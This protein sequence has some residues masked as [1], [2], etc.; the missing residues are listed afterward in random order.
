MSLLLS[1]IKNIFIKGDLNGNNGSWTNTD[2]TFKNN[3]KNVHSKSNTNKVN[4]KNRTNVNKNKAK[5]NVNDKN[6]KN[7][8]L[9]GKKWNKK[10]N[11]VQKL[12]KEIERINKI[13]KDYLRIMGKD[14][15]TPEY[16]DGFNLYYQRQTKKFKISD[17]IEKLSG[18]VLEELGLGEELYEKQ[19]KSLSDSIDVVNEGYANLTNN[20]S[21]KGDIGILPCKN[22]Y[23]A[24]WACDGPHFH[25]RLQ[26]LNGAARRKREE[27]GKNVKPKTSSPYCIQSD[28]LMLCTLP[29][30]LCKSDN[31]LHWHSTVETETVDKPQ[32]INLKEEKDSY[33]KYDAIK[34]EAVEKFLDEG[35]CD[36]EMNSN[37]F[38][39][40][41]NIVTRI[42][43]PEFVDDSLIKKVV[44][45]QMNKDKRLKEI[46]KRIRIDTPKIVKDS[47]L[48]GKKIY[49]EEIA[50]MSKNVR[51]IPD[52]TANVSEDKKEN[53]EEKLST[54][55]SNESFSDDDSDG[56]STEDEVDEFSSS[57]DDYSSEDEDEPASVDAEEVYNQNLFDYQAIIDVYKKGLNSEDNMEI[58]ASDAAL[59]FILKK[60]GHHE[61]LDEDYSIDEIINRFMDVCNN[62]PEMSDDDSSSSGSSH[63]S[64]TD[65]SYEPST[66]YSTESD[67]ESSDSNESSD[68]EDIDFLEIEKEIRDREE[69]LLINNN[70]NIKMSIKKFYL[71][72]NK[73]V[74]EINRLSSLDGKGIAI[75]P[76][77]RVAINNVR[78]AIPG[79]VA[80]PPVVPAPKVGAR[81]AGKNVRWGYMTIHPMNKRTFRQGVKLNNKLIIPM[82]KYNY[83]FGSTKCKDDEP[84]ICKI[85]MNSN[86]VK[87]NR[88]WI[89]AFKGIK[90]WL[91]E[92]DK[93]STM[94]ETYA[95]NVYHNVEESKS[96]KM[97][98]MA[99]IWN[100]CSFNCKVDRY[101]RNVHSSNKTLDL[102][103]DTYQ[104]SKDVP[105]FK[106]L[107]REIMKESVRM[108]AGSFSTETGKVSPYP[109]I[110]SKIGK[111]VYELDADYFYPENINITTYTIVRAVNKIVALHGLNIAA[112]AHGWLTNLRLN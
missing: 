13:E 59:I 100:S 5:N 77:F 7:N 69:K 92:V 85:Y 19:T 22:S 38:N 36:V 74:A 53:S 52:V 83:V 64:G 76:A 33:D 50:K 95:A 37:V 31:V 32:R 4:N 35:L 16:Q 21:N 10:A 39:K 70:V 62:F 109:W 2:D 110:A 103:R 75:L 20:R 98:I 6:R 104:F 40:V 89:Q 42:D 101:G 55:V 41:K 68:S 87:F 27:E 88:S 112:N 78:V 91:C 111:Y 80:T 25:K 30:E 12:P 93:F 3:N 24:G 47:E 44:K 17:R 66:I 43:K 84:E 18:E 82:N 102:S 58:R 72:Q 63:S 67:E 73:V 97:S 9:E 11:M 90:S 96:S 49:Q 81:K 23:S 56:E 105:S 1:C 106:N 29:A 79:I 14:D 48:S 51:E 61:E 57:E 8:K 15:G 65:D 71:N 54:V 26:P 86:E 107:Y 108:S 46:Y 34:K 28:K 94:A 45:L 60:I 99:R